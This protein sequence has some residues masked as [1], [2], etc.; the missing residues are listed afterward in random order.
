MDPVHLKSLDASPK[1]GKR[2]V[3]IEELSETDLGLRPDIMRKP[4]L[5]SSSQSTLQ[6]KERKQSYIASVQAI[7]L[8]L[9]VLI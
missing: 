4:S 9:T 5:H 1:K 7:K 2:T 6:I 3:E 8:A